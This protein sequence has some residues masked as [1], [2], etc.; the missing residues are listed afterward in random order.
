MLLQRRGG[1][2]QSLS[3]NRIKFQINHYL[4]SDFTRPSQRQ[5]IMC[6][7]KDGTNQPWRGEGKW[8]YLSFRHQADFGDEMIRFAEF[9]KHFSR[10]LASCRDRSLQITKNVSV[11]LAYQITDVTRPQTHRVFGAVLVYRYTGEF[12]LFSYP[13]MELWRSSLMFR[14][15]VYRYTGTQLG[16]LPVVNG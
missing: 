14:S 2:S 16:C 8:T 7:S 3:M 4:S 6:W 12:L 9:M 13:Y 11:Q 5:Y 15:F 1:S 10:S